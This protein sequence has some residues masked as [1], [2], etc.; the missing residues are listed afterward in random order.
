MESTNDTKA[1]K[2]K[3][4]PSY[5]GLW[6][7]F[8]VPVL[9]MIGVFIERGI[10]P[11]GDASFLRTDMYHQYAPFFSEFNYKLTHGRSLFYSWDIG[12]GVNFMALYAYYLASPLNWIIL[13]CPKGLIIEFMTYSIVVKIGLSG[14]SM[15]YYLKMHCRT[16][17]FGIAFF[18]IFYALSGYMAAYSWNIMWLD[19][20]LLFPLILYG[21][22]RL[23]H[24][25]KS[26]LY[27][28][29]LG[30]CILSNYYISIMICIFLVFYYFSLVIMEKGMTFEKFFRSGVRFAVYSLLAGGLAA[31]VLLPEIFA[32]QATASGNFS[33]PKT[34]STYFPIFDMI[35]RHMVNVHTEIGLDHWPNIY[36]GVIVMMFIPLYFACKRIPTRK[37]AVYG[38]L[39]LMLFAS[40]SINALNFI[41]HGFHFPNSLPCRQSF[42]YVF[43]V[44][45]MCYEVYRHLPSLSWDTIAKCFWGSAIFVLLAQKLIDN[46]EQFHFSV[47]YITLILL[48]LY[49]GLLYLYKHRKVRVEGLLFLAL[50]LVMAENAMNT[51]VTSVT[52]I[53]RST[54]LYENDSYVKLSKSV[55]NN[56]DFF[57]MERVDS[58]TK[59][60]G[61]WSNFPSASLFSS[62]AQ[63][64]LSDFFKEMGCESSTNAYSINGSTPFVDS[65]IALR[66]GMY[67]AEQT[68]SPLKA[69]VGSE[70]TT[71]LYENNYTLPVGFMLSDSVETRWQST[72]GN[73]ADVQ[74]NLAKTVGGEPVLTQVD[75]DTNGQSFRFTP[76]KS[77]LYYVYVSNK[78]VK[79]VNTSLGES[80]KKFSNVDRGFL[81]ELGFCE[82]GTE[83][84]LKCEEKEESLTALA[85]RFDE[86][87]FIKTFNKLN[88]EPFVT[89]S[90]SDTKITGFVE[91]SKDGILFT[92]IPYEKGWSVY[93]DGQRVRAE[94]FHDTF[95]SIP[96]T[97]GIHHIELKYAPD[98][99]YIGLLVTAIS[100]LLL[101]LLDV[102]KRI[103][104]S[105]KGQRKR[106]ERLRKNEEAK[107]DPEA[108]DLELIEELLE[109]MPEEDGMEEGPAEPVEPEEEL[110]EK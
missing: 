65:L 79:T 106:T 62:T 13:L 93:V 31:V 22:E 14:L 3:R 70:G 37:K 56:K 21:L 82:A 16:K 85:Y 40:F 29:S 32:L 96:L 81:L 35:A 78:N 33:F 48:A 110:P 24:S 52:T 43:L 103:L 91:A 5:Y 58:K 51:S 39:L 87:G 54:Y 90:V 4:T 107:A 73:P 63:K 15:A 49:A 104:I 50:L 67:P 77:G 109:E 47:F 6:A 88:E 95:L 71:Y 74:N 94:S 53:T 11:F 44:M 34:Y 75:S 72:L 1:P 46:E 42:I 18:G 100:I 108:E 38:G 92:S 41:W 25:G 99:F 68:D 59:N 97:M 57:R 27:C 20:I 55:M 9:V 23:V 83:V 105:A 28:L 10:F 64:S 30:V 45:V 60:D 36:C 26:Y 17:Q 86:D 89:E 61:A 84:V 12:M 19:C 69:L 2:A 80:S 98:G 7:A 101:I 76:E 8:L 102:G 66:Y